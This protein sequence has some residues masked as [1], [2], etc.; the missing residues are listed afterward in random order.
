MDIR[1][2]FGKI[3][4]VGVQTSLTSFCRGFHRL[5]QYALPGRASSLYISTVDESDFR[6]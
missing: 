3:V 4:C 6:A 5:G 1:G 2:R